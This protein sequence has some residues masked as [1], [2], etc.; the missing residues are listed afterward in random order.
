[1]NVWII[2]LN[3]M[4]AVEWHIG[5]RCHFHW[6]SWLV[7]IPVLGYAYA[8]TKELVSWRSQHYAWVIGWEG[9]YSKGDDILGSLFCNTVE[10]THC[11]AVWELPV[12]PLDVE[13]DHY[14]NHHNLNPWLD[15]CRSDKSSSSHQAKISRPLVYLLEVSVLH[16]LIQI[17]FEV[18]MSMISQFPRVW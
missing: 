8:L 6:L 2:K 17:P 13:I 5:W 18:E 1:M 3:T 16:S 10:A 4:T 9:R 12:K 14:A 15:R 7:G 11:F